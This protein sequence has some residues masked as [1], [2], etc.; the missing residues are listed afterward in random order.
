M[1]DYRPNQPHRKTFIENLSET[2]NITR[3]N[4]K[5]EYACSRI[6]QNSAVVTKQPRCIALAQ[7]A[8][9]T[10]QCL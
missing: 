2:K 9:Y 1:L 7:V 3:V 5:H 8:N 6:M 10:K 4:V